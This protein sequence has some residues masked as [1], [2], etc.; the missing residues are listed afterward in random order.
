MLVGKIGDFEA[1]K[2]KKFFI[3]YLRIDL[4]TTF[5]NVYCKDLKNVQ[6]NYSEVTFMQILEEYRNFL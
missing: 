6:K 4:K 1:L 3:K 5:P 2:N